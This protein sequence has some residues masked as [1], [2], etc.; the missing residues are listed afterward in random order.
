[1]K[2]TLFTHDISDYIE[3][4]L[5]RLSDL[6]EDIL[7]QLASQSQPMAIDELMDT[8]PDSSPQDLIRAL[9]SLKQRSLLETSEGRFNLPPAVMDVVLQTVED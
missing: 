9:Q 7:Y 1:M 3:E 2:T 8:L 4:I 5:D 6:E